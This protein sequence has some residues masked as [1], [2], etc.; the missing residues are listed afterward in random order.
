M[1]FPNIPKDIAREIIELAAL[2]TTDLSLRNATRLSLVSHEVQ[3]WADKFL[4]R[5]IVFPYIRLSARAAFFVETFVSDNPSLRMIRARSLVY[6]FSSRQSEDSLNHVGRFIA[7]CSHLFSLAL[8]SMRPT[9][10][11]L[12]LTIPS[13]RRMTF[14]SFHPVD[15]FQSPLFRPL[16]HLDLCASEIAQWEQL[17]TAGLTQMEYLSHLVLRATKSDQQLETVIIEAMTFLQ[18]SL[19]LLLLVL[20][21]SLVNEFLM[22]R[23]DIRYSPR[24]VIA[25]DTPVPRPKYEELGLDVNFSGRWKTWTGKLCEERTF[26]FKADQMLEA[27]HLLANYYQ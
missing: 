20:D 4:Y 26:W 22:R 24:I 14:N 19:R 11:I 8:V 16:T 9:P 1:T 3:K 12:N 23:E 17:R 18:P 15:S 21:E 6:T 13:L 2:P 25:V 5:H 27:T 10:L 7:L